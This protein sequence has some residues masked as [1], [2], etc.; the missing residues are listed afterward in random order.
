MHPF[1]VISTPHPVQ[2]A[3]DPDHRRRSCMPR[4]GP[5]PSHSPGS[6]AHTPAATKD[7]ASTRGRSTGR[8]PA[9]RIWCRRQQQGAWRQQQPLGNPTPSRITMA[10]TWIAWSWDTSRAGDVPRQYTF[11]H[12]GRAVRQWAVLATYTWPRQHVCHR[13]WVTL[14]PSS[15][16]IITYTNTWSQ[17]VTAP[18]V[19]ARGAGT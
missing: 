16:T 7:H 1:F 15:N 8:C 6:S 12:S 17:Q 2:G 4:L 13:T 18:V 10:C 11:F 3:P 14:A 9:S 5:H 19:L